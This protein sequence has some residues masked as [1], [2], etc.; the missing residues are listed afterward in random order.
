[1][2][3]EGEHTIYYYSKDWTNNIEKEQ[4]YTVTVDNTPP[5]TQSQLIG[6]YYDDG[7]TTWITTETQIILHQNDSGCGI[8]ECY[9]RIDTGPWQIYTSSIT[10][11]TTGNHT[12]EFKSKDHVE[13][14]E[15]LR[16]RYLSLDIQ[17]P[18]IT[19]TKPKTHYLYVAGREILQLSFFKDVDAVIFGPTHIDVEVDDESGIKTIELY[20]DN[21]LRYSTHDKSRLQWRWNQM[22]FRK[23]TLEIRAYDYLGHCTIKKLTI[24]V[25]NL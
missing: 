23:H 7:K 13:N 5:E 15:T 17:S 20:I 24:W 9:Y 1:L 3:S 19:I 25:F 22:A 10:L 14:E 6:G 18:D 4:S 12:L 8:Q 2:P 11:D 21:E 16:I